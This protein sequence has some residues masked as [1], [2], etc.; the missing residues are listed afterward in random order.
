MKARLLRWSYSKLFLWGMAIAIFSVGSSIYGAYK[1]A[2]NWS[3]SDE[4]EEITLADLLER[5]P[6]G[7]PHVRVKDFCMGK[8]YV[9]SAESDSIGGTSYIALVPSDPSEGRESGAI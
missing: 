3:A 4:P 6:Q 9:K 5:G 1:A 7:N 2:L 8:R